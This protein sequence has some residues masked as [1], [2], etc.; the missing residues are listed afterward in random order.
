[1][2]STVI[3]ILTMTYMT[4]SIL[5]D[6]LMEENCSPMFQSFNPCCTFADN[7]VRYIGSQVQ[8]Y[9][10]SLSECCESCHVD[11]VNC[12]HCT[13]HI[14]ECSPVSN[15]TAHLIPSLESIE[16]GENMTMFWRIDVT[17]DDV[18]AHLSGFQFHYETDAEIDIHSTISVN[19]LSSMFANGVYVRDTFLFPKPLLHTV[20]H[21][22]QNKFVAFVKKPL[23]SVSSN[24]E[25]GYIFLLLSKPGTYFNIHNVTVSDDSI[26]AKAFL[27]F[28]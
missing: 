5:N 2:I 17:L 20:F 28:S 4:A 10:T 22:T 3:T 21:D 16:V 18:N 9:V 19:S 1:M 25:D 15:V 12:P 13:L 24:L 11:L 26:P 14:P 27:N 23:E 7:N 8:E 6:K